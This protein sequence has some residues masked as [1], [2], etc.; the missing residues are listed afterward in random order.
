MKKNIFILF[1]LFQIGCFGQKPIIKDLSKETL[2]NYFLANIYETN[3]LSFE[4]IY[5]GA[6]FL[7]IYKMTDPKA[8]PENYSE[9]THE[10]VSSILISVVPDDVDYTTSKLYKIEMLSNPKIVEIKE[11][12][13]P[14]FVVSI[15]SG[16]KTKRSVQHY[17]FKAK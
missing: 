2:S 12:T 16:I 13:Y 9:G 14:E 17:T 4:E 5:K 1:I 7:R 6:F 3:K 15:E 8:T 10:V 11:T